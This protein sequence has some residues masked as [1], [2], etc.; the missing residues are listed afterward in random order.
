M[1]I[2]AGA[3]TPRRI[4]VLRPRALGDVLLATPVF[5]ALKCAFPQAELHVAV[6]DVLLPLVQRNPHIDRLWPMPRRQPRRQ[7]R[8]FRDWLR[9]YDGLARAGFDLVLDLHGSP[10]TA[11]L[12]WWT[13]APVRVGYALRGR[14]RFYSLR[15]PRDTD[16]HGRRRALYAAQ[17]NLEIL[18]RCGVPDACLADVTLEFIPDPAVE[19]EVDRWFEPLAPRRPR[20]GLSAPGTWPAKTYPLDQWAAVADG[21]AHAGCTV[22]LLWGPGEH[23]IAVDLQRRMQHDAVILPATGIDA[24]A[25]VVARL[26][27]VL[28]NDSGIKHVAVA[29][30][31]PTLTLYGPTN[32]AAWSPPTGPHAGLRSRV[33][34]LACN[35]TQCIHHLCMRLLAPDA[36]TRRA[37]EIL[38]LPAAPEAPCAS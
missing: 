16:R 30:G 11:F 17:N 12:A 4:L 8:R 18:A 27:L 2:M 6:D 38:A 3:A 25:A 22:V 5:R 37:L 1:T 28:C 21:L 10:R 20:V 33:P 9:L 29:R 36:V 34:C 13:R 32:P 35:R 15:V 23:A 14:G 26:D 31:T 19:A 7:P 24:A